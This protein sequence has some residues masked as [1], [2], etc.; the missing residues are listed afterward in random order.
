MAD[1]YAFKAEGCDFAHAFL[2]MSFCLC[3]GESPMG[4]WVGVGR[5]PGPFVRTHTCA[6][7]YVC[8]HACACM[9]VCMHVH[10]RAWTKTL[11]AH[12]VCGY[13]SLFGC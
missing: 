7:A 5:L 12:V 9:C 13:M 10:V 2:A 4:F 3:A 1:S 11:L 6:C 8:M